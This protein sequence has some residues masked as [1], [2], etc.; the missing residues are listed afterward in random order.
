MGQLLQ[1][2]YQ[3]QKTE[4]RGR[5][6]KNR[7]KKQTN[8]RLRDQGRCVGCSVSHSE[9][10]MT[11]RKERDMECYCSSDLYSNIMVEWAVIVSPA[12]FTRPHFLQ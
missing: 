3:R 2:R 8:K 10:N 5:T 12:G 11:W 6:Q 1:S 7:D 9:N 4:K